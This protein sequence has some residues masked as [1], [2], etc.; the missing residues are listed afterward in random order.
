MPASCCV[1]VPAPLIPDVAFVELPPMNLESGQVN[2]GRCTRSVNIAGSRDLERGCVCDKIETTTL[3]L[4]AHV[5]AMIKK[6]VVHTRGTAG[7][8]GDIN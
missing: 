4:V 3:G 7:P 2:Y 6:S 5:D 1:C 8:T